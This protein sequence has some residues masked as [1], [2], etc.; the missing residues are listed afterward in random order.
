MAKSNLSPVEEK[1]VRRIINQK[2]G[3]TFILSQKEMEYVVT[4]YIKARKGVEIV[5][6]IT[7]GQNPELM[8]APFPVRPG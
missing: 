1:E 4:K 3:S 5:V 8:S 7:K 6:D 2:A